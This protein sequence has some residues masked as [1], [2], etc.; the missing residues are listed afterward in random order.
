MPSTRDYQLLQPSR[1]SHNAWKFNIQIENN[2]G[3]VRHHDDCWVTTKVNGPVYSYGDGIYYISNWMVNQKRQEWFDSFGE[4][5]IVGLA[6]DPI[7]VISPAIVT[8]RA[9]DSE[10]YFVKFNW[11]GWGYSSESEEDAT[12]SLLKNIVRNWGWCIDNSGHIMNIDETSIPEINDLIRNLKEVAC[13]NR[14][15]RRYQEYQ[16]NEWLREK[17]IEEQCGLCWHCGEPLDG[18]AHKD[19][20]CR[21]HEVVKS[22]GSRVLQGHLVHVHHCHYTGHAFGVTHPICNSICKI[23]YDE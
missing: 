18:P 8:I 14:K 1:K 20:E 23:D 3:T 12:I 7:K 9:E 19:I 2:N 13:T 5:V 22:H 4:C 17:L 15:P 6:V 11:E 21:K 10:H 16:S